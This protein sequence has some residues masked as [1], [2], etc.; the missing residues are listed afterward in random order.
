MTE[1][2]IRQYFVTVEMLMLARSLTLCRK[3]YWFV[4]FVDTFVMTV[5]PC[6]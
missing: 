3:Y 2:I 6:E 1:I 4:S 5:S